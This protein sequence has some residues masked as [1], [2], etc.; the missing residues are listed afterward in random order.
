[1]TAQPYLADLAGRQLTAIRREDLYVA[2]DRAADGAGTTQP[3][4]PGAGG[5]PEL[6]RA[7]VL[8]DEA[9]RRDHLEPLTRRPLGKR[10]RPVKH[11]FQA[12]EV[13]VLDAGQTGD[14]LKHRRH[15][16][17]E[18]D[19]VPLDRVHRPR[20]VESF[21]DDQALASQQAEIASEAVGVI[22]RRQ[23]DLGGPTG[24]VGQVRPGVDAFLRITRIDKDDQFRA[25]GRA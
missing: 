2:S 7:A 15:G 6:L 9:L 4:N 5:A 22:Q 23:H 25:P 3:V 13:P 24:Q 21:H 12:A 1:M 14:P 18:V 16:D 8:D 20:G 11:V 17:H 10:C 19:P